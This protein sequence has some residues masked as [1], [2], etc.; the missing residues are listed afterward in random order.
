MTVTQQTTRS[1]RVVRS[2]VKNELKTLCL[3]SISNMASPTKKFDNAPRKT[4]EDDS[5]TKRKRPAPK[6]QNS[7]RKN[8]HYQMEAEKIPEFTINRSQRDIHE[9]KSC[10]IFMNSNYE[11]NVGGDYG[12]SVSLHC[13]IFS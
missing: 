4:I 12:P 1:G 6:T 9:K 13:I 10:S 7:P 3:G 2:P 8:V 5:P 11:D